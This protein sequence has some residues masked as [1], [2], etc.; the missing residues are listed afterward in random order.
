M[1][2]FS[3]WIIWD[4]LVRFAPGFSSVHY[5]GWRCCLSA[6]IILMLMP[7]FLLF[8]SPLCFC[9]LSFASQLHDIHHIIFYLEFLVLF[10]LVF[11]CPCHHLSSVMSTFF[12]LIRFAIVLMSFN[13]SW[14]PL[15]SR[16]VLQLVPISLLYCCNWVLFYFPI[17]Q[18]DAERPNVPWLTDLDWQTCCELDD[19]LP[20]FKDISKEITRT[21][22]HI[23]MG[24]ATQYM[25][26]MVFML[27]TRTR[28]I[29]ADTASLFLLFFYH[30]VII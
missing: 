15:S 6:A 24:N 19:T 8:P 2:P 25:Y 28:M 21:H 26:C 16:S 12:D 4:K 10:R 17:L 3:N 23:Q 5:L 27:N 20:C 9:L 14:L 18:D 13:S 11:T 22:I 29:D 7:S 30:S 1:L